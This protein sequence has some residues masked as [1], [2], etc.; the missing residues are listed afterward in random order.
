MEI[1]N[2]NCWE[3]VPGIQIHA[4][5]KIA[6]TKSYAWDEKDNT[7]FTKMQSA[8]LYPIHVFHELTNYQHIKLRYQMKLTK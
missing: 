6:G 8:V 4:W 7:D 3:R 1:I 2:F 5:T